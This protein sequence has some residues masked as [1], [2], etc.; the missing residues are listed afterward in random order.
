MAI[1]ALGYNVVREGRKIEDAVDR[2]TVSYTNHGG[3]IF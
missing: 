2:N 3:E 1:G